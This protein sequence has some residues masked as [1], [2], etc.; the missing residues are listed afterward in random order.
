MLIG[1][2]DEKSKWVSL[3]SLTRIDEGNIALRYRVRRYGRVTDCLRRLCR[4]RETRTRRVS[5]E[6]S[7][8]A[9]RVVQTSP[10]MAPS[11]RYTE[12]A[13]RVEETVGSLVPGPRRDDRGLFA[14]VDFVDL[15]RTPTS[16]GQWCAT[17]MFLPWTVF[18]SDHSRWLVATST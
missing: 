3:V 4:R 16:V 12:T 11:S 6:A 17:S 8:W 15:L 1:R 2:G 7:V 18:G 10:W 5:V 13:V 14:V 9:R